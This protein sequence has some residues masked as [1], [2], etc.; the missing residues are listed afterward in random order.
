MFIKQ[1]L[2]LCILFLISTVVRTDE[3]GQNVKGQINICPLET[4][5]VSVNESNAVC[6]YDDNKGCIRKY[7]SK[8]HL[9]IAACRDG[10]DYT[11]YSD[12][13]CTMETFICEE[14]LTFERWTIFFGHVKD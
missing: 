14:I 4:S 13:Y 2:S 3:D 12:V 5:C 1:I 6:R 7:E 11:D 10:K 8:C 9:D